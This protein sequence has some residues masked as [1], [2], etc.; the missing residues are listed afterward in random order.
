MFLLVI[1][2]H[3]RYHSQFLEIEI[4]PRVKVHRLKIHKFEKRDPGRT[5]FETIRR[6]SV[7]LP[8]G[9]AE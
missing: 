3:A 9:T 6:V 4:C 1:Q 7:F 5:I 2:T 8:T